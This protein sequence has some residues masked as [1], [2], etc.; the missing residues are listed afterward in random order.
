MKASLRVIFL[1]MADSFAV[2][3]ENKLAAI[4][5]GLFSILAFLP[6]LWALWLLLPIMEIIQG[7]EI[8]P[9]SNFVT[10]LFLLLGK[11]LG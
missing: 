7:Q 9:D 10:R 1:P 5:G 4:A 11:S 2:M 8:S 3:R 6:M